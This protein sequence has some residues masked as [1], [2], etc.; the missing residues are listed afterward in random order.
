M[1]RSSPRSK[2]TLP[3]LFD[4]A[5]ARA[6]HTHTREDIASGIKDGR[7]IYLGDDACCIVLEIVQFPQCRKL[8]VFLAAGDLDRILDAYLPKMVEIARDSGCSSIT[9]ISRKG[10][11]RHLPR[12]GFRAKSVAFELEL[13]AQ[14]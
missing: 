10:F 3:E 13:R 1:T 5:L 14:P 12:Y 11:L 7:Y 2:H 9:N 6:G 8:H 4:K